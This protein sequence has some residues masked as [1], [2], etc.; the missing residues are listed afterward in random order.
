M[1]QLVSLIIRDESMGLIEPAKRVERKTKQFLLSPQ[2]M[3]HARSLEQ[4]K[5]IRLIITTSP[6]YLFNRLDPLLRNILP[7]LLKGY[8]TLVAFPSFS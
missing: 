4:F 3:G 1:L 8:T 7:K 6:N 5:V 2:E